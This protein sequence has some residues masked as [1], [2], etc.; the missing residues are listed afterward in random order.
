AAHQHPGR[1]RHRLRDAHA[2]GPHRV[3][4]RHARLPR[5]AEELRP[6]HHRSHQ[7]TFSLDRTSDP[8]FVAEHRLAHH[9]DHRWFASA[10]EAATAVSSPEQSLD[11]AWRLHYA[12]NPAGV[13]PGFERPDL[14]R[15]DW[16]EVTVP[17]HLQLQGY[18]RPQYVNVQ[19]PWD[20]SE[21]LEPGQTPRRSN[22]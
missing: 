7:V 11:G 13:L 16:D 12:E 1:V 6:G 4:A 14:D 3:P 18:H 15:S 22:P 5:P 21:A 20:G 17:G 2:R 9:S 10:Q 19:Y 8:R